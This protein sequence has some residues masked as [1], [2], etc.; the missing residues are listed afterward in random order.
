MVKISQKI[1][2]FKSAPSVLHVPWS[3]HPDKWVAYKLWRSCNFWDIS[4][5]HDH[6]YSVFRDAIPCSLVDC[7]Q[8][9]GGT[10][11]LHL[12]DRKWELQT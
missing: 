11:S 12:Q 2:Y 1:I 8:R 5:P 10:W 6:E 4:S 9:F 3:A 7:Y